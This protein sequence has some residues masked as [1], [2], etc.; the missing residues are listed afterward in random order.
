MSHRAPK[1]PSQVASKISCYSR[2]KIKLEA[3][4]EVFRKSWG[5]LLSWSALTLACA[6]TEVQE[7]AFFESGLERCFEKMHKCW[8]VKAIYAP[9]GGG[10]TI[11]WVSVEVERYEF[12]PPAPTLAK[13]RTSLSSSAG[14]ILASGSLD[15]VSHRPSMAHKPEFGRTGNEIWVCIPEEDRRNAQA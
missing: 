2:Q 15:L 12:N 5:A 1:T 11:S 7:D 13:S 4:Y 10:W 6:E 9:I 3:T 14:G 8:G